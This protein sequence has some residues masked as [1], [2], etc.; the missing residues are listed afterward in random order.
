MRFHSLAIAFNVEPVRLHTVR[1]LPCNRVAFVVNLLIVLSRDHALR[2]GLH[3]F[4]GR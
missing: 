3:H 1:A 2:A 4:L